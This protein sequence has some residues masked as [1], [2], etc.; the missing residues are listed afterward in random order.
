M[1]K[2]LAFLLAMICLLTMVACNQTE[3]P[4]ESSKE[5]TTAGKVDPATCPHTE[6]ESDGSCTQVPRCKACHRPIGSAPGHDWQAGSCGRCG[7]ADPLG[8]KEEGVV[9]IICIGDSI[10][11]GGYWQNRMQGNLGDGY[12]VIGLGVNGATGLAEG[13]D[14][15]QPW[16]YILH[17]EYK[18]SLRYNPDAVV[19]MLG[20]NDTKGP[21]YNKIK[22]DGGA[23]YKADMIALINSYKALG[24][25]PHIFLALPPTIYRAW[26][27]SGINNEALDELL[28]QLLNEIAAETGA[29]VIDTHTATADQ[30]ALF[31]D[32]VHPNADGKA[33]I[34]KTV[35]DAV[36]AY[37]A[38]TAE[39]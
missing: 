7:K 28:L 34:A 15:G 6:L 14:Q 33:V 29:T 16:A 23:Q 27:A 5:T 31:P 2:I 37:F 13:L 9:R 32:G 35:A 4:A 19:I 26:T 38:P 10:T 36:A 8:E 11:R 18:E 1:R 17:D 20:T 22:A 12:E 25:E 39:K 24:S 30:A 21:N 3:E